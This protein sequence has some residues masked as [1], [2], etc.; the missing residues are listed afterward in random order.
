MKMAKVSPCPSP[1]LSSS[2][3]VLQRAYFMP[4]SYSRKQAF[5]TYNQIVHVLDEIMRRSFSDWTQSLDGQSFTRLEQT[6]MVRCKD[7][8][9]KL[10][11]NFDT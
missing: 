6:L 2:L 5:V 9:A 4:D 7:R 8:S 3:Q 10:D 1:I 11:F